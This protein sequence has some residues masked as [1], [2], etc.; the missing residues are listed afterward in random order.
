MSRQYFTVARVGELKPDTM[1]RILVDGRRLLLVHA[2]GRYH[3]VDEMCSHEESSLYL[4]CVQDGRIKCSL[5]GSRFDLT[6]G[7]ALDE[8]AD[9]PI[10]VHAV[11]IDGD[12]IQVALCD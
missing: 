4:G 2:N 5:H 10:G 8:P 9:A 12:E 1:K 6:S 3:A 7:E 11:R